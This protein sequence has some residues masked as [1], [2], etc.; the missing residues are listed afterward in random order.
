MSERVVAERARRRRRP[1]KQGTVLS[2]R[3]I[4]DT[5]LRLI[6]EHGA[7]ALTVRRLGASLG[8]DPSALYR[9]FRDTDDLLL[10]VATS[11]SGVRCG[12]FGRAA[13]GAPTCARWGWR[14]TPTT[15]RIRR[16][17]C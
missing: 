1:T 11:S 15:R 5:A 2:E 14:C 13:N 16:R 17:R 12:A 8:A 4:V 3:L 10:A 7:A 9:Y 6:G